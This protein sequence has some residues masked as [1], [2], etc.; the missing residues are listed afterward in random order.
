MLNNHQLDI[1]YSSTILLNDKL[2][3]IIIYYIHGS[4]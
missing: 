4:H 2:H 1:K 3:A